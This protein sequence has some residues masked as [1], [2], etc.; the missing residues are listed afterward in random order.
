MNQLL[1][2]IPVYVVFG[3][4]V[5]YCSTVIADELAS[6][7]SRRGFTTMEGVSFWLVSGLVW[8][9]LVVYA[10]YKTAAAFAREFRLAL[11]KMRGTSEDA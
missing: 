6:N 10:L 9:L 11:A 3:V 8:P 7:R 2:L 5:G 1:L 4:I